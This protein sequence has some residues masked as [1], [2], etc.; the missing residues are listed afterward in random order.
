M[1]IMKTSQLLAPIT[2]LTLLAAPTMAA[3]KINLSSRIDYTSSDNDTTKSGTPNTQGFE[4]NS[5]RIGFSGDLNKTMTY[6]LELEANNAA[7]TQDTVSKDTSLVNE[8]NV[9]INHSDALSFTFGKQFV[10]HGGFEFDYN[11]QDVYQYSLVGE[12]LDVYALGLTTAYSVMGQTFSVQIANADKNVEGTD[13]AQKNVSY[14]LGWN[15]KLGMV[16][17]IAAYNVKNKAAGKSENH[18]TFGA[19]VAMNNWFVQADYLV[20]TKENE[21]TVTKDD[22]DTSIVAKAGMTFGHLTPSFKYFTDEREVSGTKTLDRTGMVF[23]LECNGTENVRY[24]LAYTSVD[25]DYVSA[26][27]EDFTATKIYA[28]VKFDFDAM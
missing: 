22:T 17:T 11:T 18:L 12:N 13:A 14:A 15:G 23:A 5:A 19:N 24:H 8:A 7:G 6:N 28:G 26:A 1:F 16:N 27:T 2:L 9:T 21:T 3:N 10:T 20:S 25:T 4:M